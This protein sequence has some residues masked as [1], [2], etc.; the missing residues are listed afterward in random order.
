M[1]KELE[2]LQNTNHEWDRDIMQLGVALVT[3]TERVQV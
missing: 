3:A 1:I 2:K